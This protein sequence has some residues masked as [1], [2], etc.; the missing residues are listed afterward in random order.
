MKIMDRA[1][2]ATCFIDEAYRLV[3]PVVLN[4]FGPEAVET[5]MSRIEGASST[6]SSRPAFIFAGYPKE[7]DSFLRCNPG[8]ERR[9][10]HTFSFGDYSPVN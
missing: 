1:E 5:I 9:I 4:D 3:P 6:T 8:L 7:M 10:T 2:G